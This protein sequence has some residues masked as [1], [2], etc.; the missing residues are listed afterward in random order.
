MK[1]TKDGQVAF[2]IDH[3][4]KAK[5]YGVN[6]IDEFLVDDLPAFIEQIN[7]PKPTINIDSRGFYNY[8]KADQASKEKHQYQ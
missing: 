1:H 5:H 7:S 2:G 3:L 4:S 6:S 8:L